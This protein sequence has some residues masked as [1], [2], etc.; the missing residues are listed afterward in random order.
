[1]LLCAKTCFGRPYDFVSSS[2]CRLDKKKMHK[3]AV[4]VDRLHTLSCAFN[5]KSLSREGISDV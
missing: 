1:M 2:P 3:V 4:T 5:E